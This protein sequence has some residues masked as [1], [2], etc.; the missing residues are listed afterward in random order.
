MGRVKEPQPSWCTEAHALQSP[1]L[2]DVRSTYTMFSPLPPTHN[3]CKKHFEACFVKQVINPTPCELNESELFVEKSKNNL[4][5]VWGHDCP[6][7]P[8][9]FTC[10]ADMATFRRLYRIYCLTPR[11]SLSPPTSSSLYGFYRSAGHAG[12]ASGPH[13]TLLPMMGP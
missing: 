1:A 6:F 2:H 11:P 4:E 5:K 12:S 8:Q 13:R 10:L 9:N 7:Q 3:I